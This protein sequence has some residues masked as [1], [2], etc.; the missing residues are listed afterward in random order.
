MKILQVIH[1]FPPLYMAGSEVY[2][3][4]IAEELLRKGHEVTVF[5]R[6]ENPFL[7]PY[8]I[9]NDVV[10]DIPVIRVNKTRDY[11]LRQKYIDKKIDKIFSEVLSKN[12][13]QVVHVQHLSHL[14]TNIVSIAKRDFG[15]PIVYTVHD[16]WLFC[17]RGQL[18]T[19]KYE[20]CQGPD[21]KRCYNCLRYMKV[22]FDELKAYF[23]HMKKIIEDIDHFL[24]PSKVVYSFFERMGVNK[25]KLHYSPYGFKKNNIVYRRKKYDRNSSITF[26]FMGR[27]IPQKGVHILIKAFNE[28]PQ[29][30]GAKLMIYGNLCSV[31]HFI[32]QMGGKNVILMGGYHNDHVN[33][34]LDSIDV[35]VVPSIWYE[36]SPLVIHEAFLKGIPVITSDIGGMAELVKDKINGFLFNMGNVNSL[37]A[38]MERIIED[39][40]ILN[41][42]D[43][44]RNTVRDI[45]NDVDS[46]EKLY[47]E[48]TG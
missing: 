14:S 4:N 27:V 38:V 20:I 39:P 43:I 33:E 17:I 34:V 28:I 5:S 13:P 47:K 6:M 7:L 44:D 25:N 29:K 48:L 40:E 9:R 26:G 30:R 3:Y 8:T 21:I 15:L 1:G 18:L 42:L 31:E 10:D 37:R 46:L 12:I 16:F 32:R 36:N 11:T 24:I 41:D 22:S 35:L 2:T 45:Q 19:P 23:H